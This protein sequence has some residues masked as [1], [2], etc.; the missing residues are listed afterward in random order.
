MRDRHDSCAGWA[1]AAAFLAK[2]LLECH[3]PPDM[4]K[5]LLAAAIQVLDALLV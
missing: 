3:A 5:L 2:T 4:Q 1:Q